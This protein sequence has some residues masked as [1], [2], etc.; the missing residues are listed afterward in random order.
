MSRKHKILIVEDESIV[1][2]DIQD[3]LTHA[4]Y[5]VVDRVGTGK[6]ALERIEKYRPDLVLMDIKL[7]GPLNGIQTA[8]RIRK[9]HNIPV[10]YLTAYA[11]FAT[12]EKAKLTEPF[13]Y[14]LKPFEEKDLIT[15]IELAL[16][17]YENEKQLRQRLTELE[18]VYQLTDTLSKA[19][20]LDTILKQ[21]IQSIKQAL[22]PDAVG[23]LIRD[24]Q[25]FLRFKI[26][27]GVTAQFCKILEKE[28]PCIKGGAYQNMFIENIEEYPP[29][30]FLQEPLRNA[31]IVAL[32]CM[33]LSVGDE[34]LGK[35]VLYY[36]YQ[37]TF[38]E[39]EI[40]V[41][42]TMAY[43]IAFALER[44][45][46]ER[47][48]RYNEERY[49]SFYENNPSMFFTLD[50][51]FSILS[52]NKFGS[53]QLGYYS[54][55]LTGKPIFE[56]FHSD[57]HPQVKKFLK[58]TL[59][60]P[61]RIFQW[62]SRLLKKGEAILWV[63]SVARAT[64][65]LDGTVTILLVC[66]DIT[67]KKLA[68][69][70]LKESEERYRRLVEN[71]PIPIA[72]HCE[73]RWVYGNR[74]ALRLIGARRMEDVLNLPVIHIVHPKYRKKVAQRIKQVIEE[75]K[76][77][78]PFEEKM[79]RLDGKIIDVEVMGIPIDYH[80]KP[81]ALIVGQDITERKKTE[82]AL[83]KSEQRFRDLFDNAPD[84]YI[85]LDPQ[86]TV[87]DFNKRGL[88]ILGYKRE[89]II[90]KN[91]T[92]FI[93]PEDLEQAAS[94]MKHIAETGSPPKNIEVR[95]IDKQ[96]K[97]IWVSKEFSLVKDDEGNLQSI[98]V[99]CRDITE[100]KQLQAQL[101]RAQRLETAGQVAGQIAHDFNNLLAPLTAYPILIREQLPDGHPALEL[102]EE[103]ESSA[104]KIAEINQQ[105]LALGRRGHYT[106]EPIDLN[107]LIEKV[108][109]SQN[110]PH[111]IKIKQ[112]FASDL[113][114]IK[115]GSAQLIRA[116]TNLI[117]NAIEA[118]PTGGTLTI[119]TRNVYLDQPLTRYQTIERGEYVQL[120]ISDTG[121]GIEPDIIDKIFDPFFTTKKMDRIR[122]SGLGLSIVHS[123]M[124]DHR[125]YITVDS[126]P[127]KCTTFTLYFPV[128]REFTAEIPE[129]VKKTRGGSEKILVV[130][131]D[132]VQRRVA[133][134]ILKRLGYYVH[135][136]SSGE[137]AVRYI[138]K[139]PQDLIVLDMVMD[140]IDGTET[141]RQILK[142]RPRQ[143][144]IIVSGF[145]M[146]QRVQEALRLGAGSFVSKPVSFNE[147]AAAVRNELDR[148]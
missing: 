136:V 134:Q 10:V 16:Y 36:K 57:D 74:A 103:I 98:R 140:G 95:L 122:G 96:G 46:A 146:S 108:V 55:E 86:A 19:D 110:I 12:I 13:G 90:G 49:R 84:M 38:S 105:L 76:E 35:V 107:D 50:K 4:G 144:A 41:I 118:M 135:A 131:D 100:R 51:K 112:E 70:A 119:R 148:R 114:F 65:E 7:K 48:L 40:H 67:E 25:G 82:E 6:E 142:Q 123:I 26:W 128:T 147:L 79:I 85:I 2:L 89:E 120:E 130:D 30:E 52:V 42:K 11:D 121:V 66:E 137:E 17:K 59:K 92:G 28:L 99:V 53:N 31:G 3:S 104:S 44:K 101:E 127:G 23:I 109:L 27:E 91:I 143:K 69:D 21:A 87:L 124:E 61:D 132:P 68:E 126:T 97:R 63:R 106:M 125:G 133:C 15:T 58:N 88:N 80:G 62:D 18:A 29:I 64:K 56:L 34:I 94:V 83:R 115:G 1:A 33:P 22:N 72:V 43:H 129:E 37:H 116:F 32:A 111:T 81:A 73:G 93:D 102:V 141:Y 139:H 78:P 54:G 20:S 145:A 47:E 138:K 60:N 113:F 71:S 75:R 5:E 24:E 117:R 77:T 9:E 14:L 39:H 45:E 8:Q